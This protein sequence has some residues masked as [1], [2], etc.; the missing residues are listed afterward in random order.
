MVIQHI[1]DPL[2]Q[3]FSAQI[4]RLASTIGTTETELS[5]R[6]VI[7]QR[8]EELLR[9]YILNSKVVQFGSAIT[10]LGTNDSDMDLCLSFAPNETSL[11]HQ[12]EVVFRILKELRREKCGF[13]KSLYAVSDARCP[14]IRFRAYDGHLV[15]LSVNNTI[16]YQKS[17]YLGALVQADQSGLLR[18][19]I[20]ALRFWAASNGVFKSERK[21]TWNL[22]SYTM[23]LMFLTFLRMEEIVPDFTHSDS[24]EMVNGLRVDFAVPS[25]TLAGIDF[26]RLFKKFFVCCVEGHLD[27]LV[28]S[29]RK[30]A[31]VPLAELDVQMNSKPESILFVQNKFCFC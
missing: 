13:F 11:V 16:G 15:E 28:F 8:L 25:F 4:H 24:P 12:T 19:L 3:G 5:R 20:L 9:R 22:N 29:L 30:G 31:L 14:V 27:K 26:R 18:E 17:A 1:K 7:C 10:G 6:T 2:C 21:K 23:T